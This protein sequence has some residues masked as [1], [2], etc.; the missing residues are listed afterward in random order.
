MNKY[1]ILLKNPNDYDVKDYQYPLN[2]K[3]L[4]EEGKISG[5]NEQYNNIL[6]TLVDGTI[7]PHWC[8][9]DQNQNNI[10][11]TW[12]KIPYISQSG[13]VQIVLNISDQYISDGN[14]KDVFLFFDD[15]KYLD[16]N[17]WELFNEG[18]EGI[19]GNVINVVDDYN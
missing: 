4:V 1:Y 5:V 11:I 14:G 16:L 9:H 6:F 17:T 19:G 15:F 13:Y 10:G 12:I 18:G 3:K 8:E 7:L 2:I